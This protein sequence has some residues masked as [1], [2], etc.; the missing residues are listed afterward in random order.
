MLRKVLA[1]SDLC[2]SSKDQV[3]EV[4]QK[5]LKFIFSFFENI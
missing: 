3:G 5:Y 4:L 1:Q 2:Q